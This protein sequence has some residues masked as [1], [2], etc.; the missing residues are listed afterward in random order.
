MNYVLQKK[1]KS[2]LTQANEKLLT[3]KEDREKTHYTEV[4]RRVQAIPLMANKYLDEELCA[5]V[6]GNT[7][8]TFG[9]T[10]QSW[11]EFFDKDGDGEISPK[12]FSNTMKELNTNMTDDAMD[13]LFMRFK[14][15]GRRGLVDWKAFI[16]FY[17][18][19][20]MKKATD[21]E[22]AKDKNHLLHDLMNVIE[23]LLEF[24][25]HAKSSSS[26]EKEVK[27]NKEEATISTVEGTDEQKQTVSSTREDSSGALEMTSLHASQ[28]RQ[29]IHVL[30]TLGLDISYLNMYRI[31][32]VFS[33]DLSKLKLFLV[34]CENITVSPSKLV[35]VLETAEKVTVGIM[36]AMKQRCAVNKLGFDFTSHE[37]LSKLW[38]AMAPSLDSDLDYTSLTRY[39]YDLFTGVGED[40]QE[41]SETKNGDEKGTLELKMPW[42]DQSAKVR[43]FH[44]I[45]FCN[46]IAEEIM[47]SRWNRN[48]YDDSSDVVS[49]I[50][51][52]AFKAFIQQSNVDLIEQKLQY[53]V[54]LQECSDGGLVNY[55]VHGYIPIGK[56]DHI[57]FILYDP[58]S[59][60]MF[61]LRV[62]GDVSSF[63]VEKAL[64]DVLKARYPHVKN[65]KKLSDLNI[66][67]NYNS[68][69]TPVE[70]RSFN[71]L[72]SRFRLVN[73]G[74]HTTLTVAE[75]PKFVDKLKD[76]MEKANMPFFVI[77]NEISILFELSNKNA[78][79]AGSMQKLVFG[80]IRKNKS[81]CNFLVNVMSDLRVVLRTYD[82]EKMENMEWVEMLAYLSGLRNPFV[83]VQLLPTYVE[84]EMGMIKHYPEEL[85]VKY[86]QQLE[87]RAK[88]GDNELQGK[89]SAILEACKEEDENA[90]E[91]VDEIFLPRVFTGPP[92]V[93]GGCHPSWD[94]PFKMKFK[95]PSLT[96]CPVKFT[97]ICELYVEHDKKYMIVM[98]R[99]AKDQSLFMTAYDPR[100]STEYMLFG[101]PPQWSLPGISTDDVY[102]KVFPPEDEKPVSRDDAIQHQLDE[103]IEMHTNIKINDPHKKLRLGFA[104]TPRLVISVYNRSLTSNE[105]LLGSCQIS[106]SSVLSGSGAHSRQWSTLMSE[107]YNKAGI[108]FFTESG[109]LSV[110]LGYTKKAELEALK[111]AKLEYAERC[112][113]K[114]DMAKTTRRAEV[115]GG[116]AD[117][118]LTRVFSNSL[119]SVKVM[120]ALGSGS[121]SNEDLVKLQ[122]LNARLANE[123]K[124]TK[125][126]ADMLI[127]EK[128]KTLQKQET[129]LKLLSDK[130]EKH[131]S[132]PSNNQN[133]ALKGDDNAQQELRE[134]KK[135][136]EELERKN[137]ELKKQVYIKDDKVSTAEHSIVSGTQDSTAK[138]VTNIAKEMCN[139]VVG[140]LTS[141][142][143]FLPLQ[144]LATVYQDANACLGVGA[145]VSI[146][147]AL[148]MQDVDAEQCKVCIIKLYLQLMIKVSCVDDV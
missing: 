83:T 72:C 100:S 101:G 66:S 124:Q 146:F 117:K 7:S 128:A 121:L 35:P 110:D 85:R 136:N 3:H 123:V 88:T 10:I 73:N 27:L 102:F 37:E 20:I 74:T 91:E 45:V 26:G 65:I 69:E 40:K 94:V 38:F 59:S 130:L 15:Y 16:N 78:I 90:E 58:L 54:H 118:S 31:S 145:M 144:G 13:M 71:E 147:S 126:E 127:A 107:A 46:L 9:S 2:M 115:L 75:D 62:D 142:S 60:S 25:K 134:A 41:E 97:D 34:A 84:P 114:M 99:E 50:S 104:I 48:V 55:L 8:F 125:K 43:N 106:I 42:G 77:V 36:E 11:F 132:Q 44:V 4:Y 113:E 19:G 28:I 140:E 122:T 64:D 79:E 95:P 53:L 103:T 137:E 93:D 112:K 18:A 49:S 141:Q 76:L 86:F 135:R 22:T 92:D 63:P 56:K 21:I 52:S 96:S 133:T 129:E 33:F 87:S 30:K 143:A 17:E 29:N 6:I 89:V 1:Q 24:N 68:V 32:R 80:S 67:K 116:T 131:Q 148:Q 109:L 139:R 105:E 14:S 70:D 98:V 51:Y 23:K 108:P 12:E 111:Q 39:F 5:K 82:G 61:K 138:L 57:I 81:L 47:F 120:S 119:Q